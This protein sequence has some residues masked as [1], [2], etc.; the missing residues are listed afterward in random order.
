MILVDLARRL[1]STTRTLRNAT[2]I[3]E[4]IL[5]EALSEICRALLEADVNAQLVKQLRENIKQAI[6][7]EETPG[8]LNINQLIESVVFTELVRLIDSEVRAWQPAKNKANIVL[9]VGLQGS[10]KTTTCTKYAYH[11]MRRGWKT[12]LVCADTFRAGAFDQLKQNAT[13]ARIPFYGSYTESDPLLVAM[14]GIETFRNDNFELIIVD[15]SGRHAQEESLFEEMLHISNGIQPDNII[16]VVDASIGQACE[17]QAKAF[18]SK[19][20]VGSVIIT[21]LDGHGKGGGALSAVAA[22][23]SSIIFIGTGEHIDDFEVF[24]MKQ[25][26]GKLLGHGN[27]A[28]LTERM[29]ELKLENNSRLITN[30]IS[31]QFKLRD[32]IFIQNEWTRQEPQARL[33]KLM[34]IMDSMH[35]NELD[36]SDVVKLFQSQIGRY[37]RVARG[38]GASIQDVKDLLA[39]YSKFSKVIKMMSGMNDPLQPG[40]T[41]VKKCY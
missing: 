33:K 10:G 12:A 15:T 19:V 27:I 34:C 6:N 8:R 40:N 29:H 13:K 22:T 1:L 17:L 4:Q 26:I 32:I 7:L 35:T 21:K 31:G 2:I 23:K 9:F 28:G 38:S 25:F 11:Y 14:D 30:L 24:E 36:H 20:D 3:N 41:N 39:Q 16:F 18:K 37:T 5:N